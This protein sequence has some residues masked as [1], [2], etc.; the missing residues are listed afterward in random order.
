MFLCVICFCY[1]RIKRTSLLDLL[2]LTLVGCTVLM[3]GVLCMALL[4]GRE[5]ARLLSQTLQ[6]LNVGFLSKLK[7]LLTYKE[8][9]VV[10]M[11]EKEFAREVFVR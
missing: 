5:T 4:R 9:A 2:C 8:G 7:I 11:L 1:L 10:A 3:Y 6:K